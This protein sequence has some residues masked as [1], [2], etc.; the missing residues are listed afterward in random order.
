MADLTQQELEEAEALR[1]KQ[2]SAQSIGQTS[3]TT[4]ER[5]LREL[6]AIRREFFSQYRDNSDAENKKKGLLEEFLLQSQPFRDVKGFL[7]NIYTSTKLPELLADS[8]ALSF[9]RII[10]SSPDETARINKIMNGG[11]DPREIKLNGTENLIEQFAKEGVDLQFINEKVSTLAIMN[12]FSKYHQVIPIK[13]EDGRT[14]NLDVKKYAKDVFEHYQ[15]EHNK[16]QNINPGSTNS[17]PENQQHDLPGFLALYAKEKFLEKYPQE[18]SNFLSKEDNER[19]A[20]WKKRGEFRDQETEEFL[21]KIGFKKP[22]LQESNKRP[23]EQHSDDEVQ[24]NSEDEKKPIKR[25]LRE[26]TGTGEFFA[27]KHPENQGSGI[28]LL[29][30]YLTALFSPLEPQKPSKQPVAEGPELPTDDAQNYLPTPLPKNQAVEKKPLDTPTYPGNKK[31]KWAK[32]IEEARTI[33]RRPPE[34]CP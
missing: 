7:K 20:G 27:E 6:I 28:A 5:N 3:L 24:Q 8:L 9:H 32:I 16:Q 2:Q 12:P 17:H 25:T 33:P 30:N 26:P 15:L 14:L 4:N 18:S 34:R 11:V 10:D 21:I 1:R 13:L 31:V 29:T 19:I 23:R 22:P